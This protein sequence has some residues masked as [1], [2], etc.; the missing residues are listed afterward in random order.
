MTE[1]EKCWQDS[2]M[3]AAMQ[4]YS[5]VRFTAAALPVD[6]PCAPEFGFAERREPFVQAKHVIIIEFQCQSQGWARLSQCG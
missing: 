3:T 6:N 2:S 5:K 4:N 1:R